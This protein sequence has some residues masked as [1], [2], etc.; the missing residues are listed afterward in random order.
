MVEA[1]NSAF[2]NPPVVCGGRGSGASRVAMRCASSALYTYVA[3]V[4]RVWCMCVGRVSRERP[5]RRRQCIAD[6]PLNKHT[7]GVVSV[8]TE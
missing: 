6:L 2:G 3:R 4:S 7:S 1:K 8:F 5:K